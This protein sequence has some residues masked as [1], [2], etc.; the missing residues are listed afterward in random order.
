MPNA[1]DA[2]PIAKLAR[3]PASEIRAKNRGRPWRSGWNQAR[4]ALRWPYIRR[5]V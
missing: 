5:L 2:R 4:L 1:V 3:G